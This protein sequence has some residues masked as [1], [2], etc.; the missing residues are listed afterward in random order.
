M[1]IAVNSAPVKSLVLG[2]M[3]VNAL[4]L[5]L[6]LTTREICSRMTKMTMPREESLRLGT[7]V[8]RIRTVLLSIVLRLVS[9]GTT[10]N[11]KMQISLTSYLI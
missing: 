9:A 7:G 3:S 8:L 6:I 10:R 4:L 1:R 5:D 2:I 11:A